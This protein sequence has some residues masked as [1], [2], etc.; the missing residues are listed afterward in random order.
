METEKSGGSSDYSHIEEVLQQ[1]QDGRQQLDDLWATR[2]LKLDLCL[3]L[4]LFEREALDVCIRS[5]VGFRS[6]ALQGFG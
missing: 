4:R 1:L 3:Q 6:K 2:K 5:S